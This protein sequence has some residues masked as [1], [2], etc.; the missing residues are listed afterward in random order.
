MTSTVHIVAADS[1]R[2]DRYATALA[3]MNCRITTVRMPDRIDQAVD[4]VVFDPEIGDPT[5][6]DTGTA[7][8]EQ[9]YQAVPME[10][11]GETVRRVERAADK[12]RFERSID[13]RFDSVSALEDD[14]PSVVIPASL[15]APD[16]RELYEAL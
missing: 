14:R 11:V 9:T 4:V 7:A 10:G 5:A 2:A 15:G 13:T 8:S 12:R 6:I 16:F 3:H 1:R